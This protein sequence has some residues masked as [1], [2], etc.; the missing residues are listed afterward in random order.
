MLTRLL[1]RYKSI[2]GYSH[3]VGTAG[4]PLDSSCEVLYV[5]PRVRIFCFSS[6]VSRLSRGVETRVSRVPP[7]ECRVIHVEGPAANLTDLRD[8]PDQMNLGTSR[9][10]R[11]S[12]LLPTPRTRPLPRPR[13]QVQ[14][15]PASSVQR[16][17]EQRGAQQEATGEAE[18]PQRVSAQARCAQVNLFIV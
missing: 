3:T 18:P 4:L 16:P 9:A 2:N 14:A 5:E 10:S 7:T 12:R 11:P 13:S 8:P 1:E 17:S 15:V 6:H